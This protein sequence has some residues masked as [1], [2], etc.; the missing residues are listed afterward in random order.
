MS[1]VFLEKCKLHYEAKRRTYPPC[2]AASTLTGG[3]R[4]QRLQQAE[5]VPLDA[6]ISLCAQKLRSYRSICNDV[7]SIYSTLA[8]LLCCIFFIAA[9]LCIEC[10]ADTGPESR[11]TFSAR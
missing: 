2:L 4:V 7:W 8:Q 9:V 11:V 6:D 3:E 10:G 5:P 1:K